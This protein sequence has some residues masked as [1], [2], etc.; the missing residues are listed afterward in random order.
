MEFQKIHTSETKW[1]I[2]IPGELIHQNEVHVWRVSLDISDFQKEHLSTLLASEELERAG[3]FHFRKD[4]DHF[5]TA[6]GMLRKI[7]A[8]YLGSRPQ[9]LRFEYNSYGKPELAVVNGF[10]KLHFNLSHSGEYALFAFTRDGCIGIDIEQVRLDVDV[11]QVSRRFFSEQERRFLQMTPQDDRVG[12]FYQY[13][14]RKE[15]FIK[16][17]G[18]GVSF[19]M[20][21]CDVSSLNGECLVPVTVLEDKPGSSVW[22]GQDLFPQVGYAAAVVVEGGDNR[23]VIQQYHGDLLGPVFS[24]I[25]S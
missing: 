9:E 24:M 13:W 4:Q 2:T 10:E 22:F 8:S 20:E 5:I 25:N 16:A 1:N 17:V 3:K 6:R 21:N 7:L 18:N 14:T 11:E 23:I 12:L 19:Q 15:A